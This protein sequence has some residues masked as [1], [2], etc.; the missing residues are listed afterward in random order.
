METFQNEQQLLAWVTEQKRA[1]EPV[2]QAWQR[3]IAIDMSYYEGY[4]WTQLTPF[5]TN[6]IDRLKVDLNPDSPEFRATLNR[7]TPLVQRAAATTHP[8]AMEIR[9]SPPRR[10]LGPVGT[11]KAQLNEDVGNILVDETGFVSAWQDANFHRHVVGCYGIG[12]M[13]RPGAAT[14]VAG[15]MDTKAPTTQIHAFAYLPLKLILDPAV[16]E[17]DLCK[18]DWVMYNDVWSYRKVMRIYGDMLKQ[19]GIAVEEN[20]LREMG[21]L[22]SFEITLNTLTYN[23]LFP[24]YQVH[25]KTKGMTV[26]HLHRKDDA[27]RFSTME[28]LLEIEPG[29]P[30]LLNPDARESPFGGNGLPL[31]LLHGHR[32]ADTMFS[33]GDTRM[34]KDDQ[35]RLNRTQTCHDRQMIHSS[36]HQWVIDKASF[37]GARSEKEVAKRITNAVGGIVVWESGPKDR[38]NVEPRLVHVPPPQATLR[39]MISEYQ[40]SMRQQ[41]HRSASNFGEMLSHVP[42]RSY[43][44]GLD[45]AG[46]VF[47]T[48]VNEDKATCESLVGVMIGTA[49]KLAAERDPGMLAMLDR[50]QFGAD[51]MLAIAQDDP[52]ECGCT[53]SISDA[54]IRARSW[55]A[56]K[57]DID[58]AVMN[59]TIDA[60]TARR[61]MASTL[62]A[63][64]VEDDRL[65]ML[66]FDKLAADLLAGATD[67]EPLPLGAE[68]GV[69]LLAVLEKALIC[70]DA[71]RDPAARQRISGAIQSQRMFMAQMAAAEQ[72]AVGGHGM[73]G[74]QR[75]QTG[76]QPAQM[77]DSGSFNALIDQM[78]QQAVAA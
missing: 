29:K 70:P 53:L 51:E 52:Y 69:D 47:D 39:D 38:P 77:P 1:D 40:E 56:R 60:R 6:E 14:L 5:S 66:A 12:L 34:C 61:E 35:D 17:R 78:S 59:R 21:T 22:N 10:N 18:H 74:D 72:Q 68:R 31:R 54:S 58:A 19:R 63:P 13:A 28:I 3:E 76:G 25:S 30:I 20:R 2:K 75:M 44:R 55:N 8:V 27:E 37:P 67:F 33:I 36:K 23:R 42:D 4:G 73:A 57:Q 24:Q 11:F 7:T 50:H 62:D 16:Q 71:V 65:F 43:Q 46:A 26:T 15:G 32:R 48:W 49:K 64:V 45:E 41:T 9:C